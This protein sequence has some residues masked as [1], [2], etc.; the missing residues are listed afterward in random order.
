MTAIKN[1][2]F[3]MGPFMNPEDILNIAHT[4]KG[5]LSKIKET[6]KVIQS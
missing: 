2:V 1:L 5:Y 3:C 6:L 4:Q